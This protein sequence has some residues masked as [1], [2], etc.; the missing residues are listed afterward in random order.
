MQK[1]MAKLFSTIPS[2]NRLT[3][4]SSALGRRD[5]NE[6]VKAFLRSDSPPI[7]PIHRPMSPPLFPRAP[8]SAKKLPLGENMED[9]K[10]LIGNEMDVDDDDLDVIKESFALVNGWSK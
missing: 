1:A 10:K 8:P 3:G 2:A 5:L 6:N 4:R 7:E 9:L